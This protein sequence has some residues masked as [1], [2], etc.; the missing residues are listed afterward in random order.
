MSSPAVWPLVMGFAFDRT[1]SYRVPL[2]GFCL[3]AVAAAM[4]VTRL[5]PYRFGALPRDEAGGVEASREAER[6]IS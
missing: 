5:G 1:G 2:A 6:G 4:L 3:A